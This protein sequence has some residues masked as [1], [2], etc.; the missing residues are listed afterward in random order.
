MATVT[1]SIGEQAQLKC[2]ICGFHEFDERIAL[3]NTAGAV[4]AGLGWLDTRARCYVC[5]RCG[6]IHWFLPPAGV[7]KPS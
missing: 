6:F 4:F 2:Q 5:Q 7:E 1:V 3:L